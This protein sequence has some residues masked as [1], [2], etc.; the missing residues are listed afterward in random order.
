MRLIF[1]VRRKRIVDI[2]VIIVLLLMAIAELV[3]PEHTVA[4]T[5]A[6]TVSELPAAGQVP[7]RLNNL[8]DLAGRGG[9]SV[10]GQTRATTWSHGTLQP[11]HLGALPGGEYSSA[12]AIND[13]GQVAGASNTGNAIVPFIW[14]PTGGLQRIPLLRGD[15]CGQGLGINKYGHVAGYSSG[16]NGARAFLWIP[17]TGVRNLGSLPGG[18]YSRARAVN[19]SDEVVGTSGSPAGDRAVL[20]TTTGNVRDLGTLPGDASSEAVAINT[21]GDVVGYS[22]G[23]GGLRAFLWTEAN[24]MQ[25]LGVLS[26]DTSSR[27]LDINDSGYVV[28][29]S[30]SLSADHA[31]IW[32]KQSG[33]SDLN[34]AASA[35]L[36]VVFVEAQAI[37]S[38]GEIL[39][40]GKAAQEAAA[41]DE[42][43]CAP[44]APL[45]FVLIPV[46]AK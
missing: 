42:H 17:K 35:A 27:A 2:G 14:K 25:D 22:V 46:A 18:S 16:P 33:M 8:G 36:G 9:S 34:S 31:F 44:A 12:F 38:T 1:M 43:I 19:D 5:L 20:W 26:G 24:G 6:Y 40:M 32:T 28:G 29:S 13:A 21:A 4:Q 15:K 23:P 45:S 37:N 41:P 10:A 3:F 39:V 11:K 7:C 30:G